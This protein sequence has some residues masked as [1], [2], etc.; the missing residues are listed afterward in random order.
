MRSFKTGKSDKTHRPL[1]C[2]R[3]TLINVPIA[4]T[5]DEKASN[6][7]DDQAEGALVAVSLT[8]ASLRAFFHMHDRV[9]P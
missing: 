6:F 9:L 4:R 1:D 8:L 3:G 2:A 7:P 5:A